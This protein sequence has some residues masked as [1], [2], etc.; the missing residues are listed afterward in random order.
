[1]LTVDLVQLGRTGSV[2]V[3]GEWSGDD[4]LWHDLS[5][6]WV[7]QL[8][9]RFRATY[10]GSGEVVVRG[11]SAG[12]L[13]QACRRCLES[14][15]TSFKKELT[16]VF[17]ADPSGDEDDGGV[18]PLVPEGQ[19]LELSKAV[20]EEMILAVNPYVIC[21]PD[22]QGLCPQCGTNLNEDSCTCIEEANDPRWGPLQDL[23]SE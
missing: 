14:V 19:K 7:G 8:V 5:F 9:A 22:C 1:M 11:H 12:R 2:V 10:A 3:E 17:V 20:R 6:S 15:E 4:E 18:H 23:K 21:D 13:R 16:M